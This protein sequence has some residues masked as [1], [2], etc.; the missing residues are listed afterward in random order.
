ML[1][2]HAEDLY[3]A[4]RYMER[5]EG[6]ARMLDV[7]YRDL[8]ER[9][10]AASA[11]TWS[12]LLRI[13]SLEEG[14]GALGEAPDELTVPRF[15][16]AGPDNPAS[17][18]ANVDRLRTN[19]RNVRDR[20][21]TELWEAVNTFYLELDGRDL[22]IDM[23]VR[24]YDLYGI[25]KNRCQTI[26]GVASETM[27]RNDGFRFLRIG[28]VLERAEMTTRMLQVRFEEV[29]IERREDF[30]HLVA[31]LKSVSAFEAYLK[32]YRAEVEPERVLEL[33]LFAQDVPRSVLFAL[34][35]AERQLGRVDTESGPTFPERLLGRVRAGLEYRDVDEVLA[36]GLAPFLDELLRGIRSLHDAIYR[37]FF[38]GASDLGLLTYEI[39]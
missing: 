6:A 11:S 33:I 7:T 13:L 26:A 30:R 10:S 37:Q 8:L 22:T 24:P 19:A 16:L 3:W 15:V 32:R 27:P 23:A 1:S 17:V 36:E 29:D 35:E 21:P 2:R 9:S 34:L 31:V 18:V 4:G 14:F 12:D 20:I 28:R 5:V 39:T 38:L 25:L